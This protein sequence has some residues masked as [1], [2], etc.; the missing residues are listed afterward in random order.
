MP[1]ITRQLIA[2]IRALLRPPVSYEKVLK[3]NRNQPRGPKGSPTGG[4]WVK[5]VSAGLGSTPEASRGASWDADPM[6]R[7]RE[8][9]G[10]ADYADIMNAPSGTGFGNAPRLTGDPEVVARLNPPVS[11][12]AKVES[13]LKSGRIT[14]SDPLGEGVNGSL[15]VRFDNGD[16]AIF[17]PE[18]NE[19]WEGGFANDSITDYVTNR[20]FSL[21][22]RE[23]FAYEA[24]ELLFGPEKNPVPV[25]ILREDASDE[26]DIPESSGDEGGYDSEYA[27]EQYD[28]YK[29]KAQEQAMDAVG[30]EMGNLWSEHVKEVEKRTEE[31]QEVWD[32]MKEEDPSI[33]AGAAARE[34]PNL[35]MGSKP[36]FRP[37]V[38]D[39]IEPWSVLKE[40]NVDTSAPLSDDE[41]DRIR[42]ILEKKA[43]EGAEKL[44]SF[45][46][47]AYRDDEYDSWLEGH[48]DTE[49]RMYDSKIQ[50]FTS[51]RKSQG[52]RSEGSGDG[53]PKNSEA[54]NPKGGSFQLMI[55]AD[56]DM[57]NMEEDGGTRMAVL[58][59]AIG[60]MDRHH[61]NVM[62]HKG[63]PVA[64]DNGYSMPDAY[65]EGSFYFRSISVGQW[66]EGDAKPPENLRKEITASIDAADW[67]AL[68]ARHP[69]MTDGERQG[70]LNRVKRVREALQTP[71]GLYDMW[72]KVHLMKY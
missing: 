29:E 50:S 33:G 25:T 58:D 38:P 36:S 31:V 62:G 41:K 2:G 70:F 16:E 45:D 54:P 43:A 26:V 7:R 3:F 34:Y 71:D 39:D 47:D 48:A 21:A 22:E 27:R 32:E 24:G 4:Q 65:D 60:S 9:F 56:G 49:A 52:Y 1:H 20:N 68:V 14:G 37:V 11:G 28:K 8:R 6:K 59:Y 61:A 12:H 57:G 15:R 40:A 53:G 55:D 69:S 46:E 66:M 44:G 5:G 63:N 13:M 64:I 10:S 18:V 42:E 19:T 72:K 30:E 23:V 51:W 17:K 67:T 35:P